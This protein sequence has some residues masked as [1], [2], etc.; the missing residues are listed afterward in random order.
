[1]APTLLMTF[2]KKKKKLKTTHRIHDYFTTVQEYVNYPP[3]KIRP[4][5]CR[6]ASAQG[7]ALRLT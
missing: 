5:R 6:L 3:I 1:M 4:R 2:S 7:D